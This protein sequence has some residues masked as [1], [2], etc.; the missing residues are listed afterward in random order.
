MLALAAFTKKFPLAEVVAQI[1]HGSPPKFD[2]AEGFPIVRRVY[3]GRS[4]ETNVV[5]YPR[6]QFCTKFPD[7]IIETGDH[8]ESVE[9]GQSAEGF[10]I[11]A[12]TPGLRC[13]DA[14]A[15]FKSVSR[16]FTTLLPAV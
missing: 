11:S 2:A 13:V 15:A 6:A 12:S 3:T 9:V 5:A 4:E 14:T 10:F 1:S 16:L 7:P 8:S